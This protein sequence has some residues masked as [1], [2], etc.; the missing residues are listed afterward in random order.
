MT[1]KIRNS[2]NNKALFHVSWL[3]F[4]KLFWVKF[5]TFFE[6][7]IR[8]SALEYWNSRT[9]L[10][11]ARSIVVIFF[12]KFFGIRQPTST[13]RTSS[14]KIGVIALISRSQL[15]RPCEVEVGAW[16][17]MKRSIQPPFSSDYNMPPLYAC[18]ESASGKKGHE[19]A[20][21]NT[22]SLARSHS[23]FFFANPKE[24]SG[25]LNVTPAGDLLPKPLQLRLTI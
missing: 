17:D 9:S 25:L 13:R 24:R 15:T 3:N 4:S 2:A 14:R 21:I 12:G 8:L 6:E 22:H 19:K 5:A 11:N 7:E 16:C 18:L 20:E 23:L 10:L 1:S